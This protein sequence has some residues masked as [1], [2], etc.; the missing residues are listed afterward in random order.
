VHYNDQPVSG[1]HQTRVECPDQ[2]TTYNLSVVTRNNQQII[3]QVHVQV[4]GGSFDRG[5][6]E[7]YT[8][9][10]VDFDEDGR[11]SGDEDDFRWIWTGGEEG[12]MVKADDDRDL[13]LA[14]AGEGSDS[15]FDR[16]S[17]D[18]C[19][20][21]LDDDDDSQVELEEDTIVCF[22]TD[23]GDYGKFRVEDIRRTNGRLEIDWYIW[24]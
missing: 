24:K 20:D 6:L 22:R 12:L 2:S 9:E 15:R 5:D 18:E 4:L 16:L 23:S 10:M 1:I 8:G 3:K 11:V 13:R 7:M 21:R 14:R 17:R 19:R